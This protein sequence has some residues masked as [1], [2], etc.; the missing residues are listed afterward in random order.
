MLLPVVLALVFT[1]FT[2]A[3]VPAQPIGYG[4][5]L[6]DNA[7]LQNYQCLRSQQYS[8]AF[9]GIYNA[10]Q[11]AVYNYAI[12]SISNAQK[13]GL[14]VHI[15]HAAAPATFKTGAWPNN[16][17]A[18]IAFINQFVAAAA[19]V[20]VNVAFYTNWYDWEQITGGWVTTPRLLW[21]WDSLG[22]GQ[23]AYGSN[24]F[25]DFR[26]FGGFTSAHVGI[27][28]YAQRVT[29]CNVLCNVNRFHSN[30]VLAQAQPVR[31]EEKK[32]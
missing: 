8:Y 30:L 31:F 14:N 20:N 21:Y 27:K 19:Q 7:S 9:V 6:V 13:A 15:V 26:G 28:Q 23:N 11:G 17:Q 25:N 4:V 10:S 12:N 16:P 2:R 22:Y 1:A 32:N 24:D 29:T 5:D 18:N 3:Q